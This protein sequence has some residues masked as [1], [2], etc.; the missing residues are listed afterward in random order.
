MRFPLSFPTMLSSVW[1]RLLHSP[2]LP[3]IFFPCTANPN[4]KF[5]SF[6]R[7]PISSDNPNDTSYYSSLLQSCI[8]RKSIEPGKQLHAHILLLGLGSDPI[9]GTKL[10]NLYSVCN[11]L[12]YAH[13]LFDKI[14][15][16]NIFLWNVLIRGYA[17][18]GPHEVALSLYY[19]ILDYGLK[20]DNF[21]FPFVLKACSALSAIREGR[22]IH[23][24]V[25]QT[26]WESDVFVGAALVDMY[27]KCGCVNNA[28]EVF[29]R[30][31]SRDVVLWNSMIAA[32]SQN[33]HPAEAL[34]LCREMARIGFRP[35]TATLVTVI[36]ASSDVAALPQGREIHGF[37]WRHGF[38]SQDKVKTALID[39][40]AK[41]G[42]VRVARVLFER[43]AEKRVISWNAMIS[44]YGMHGH[45]SKALSLF[46]EMKAAAQPDHITFVGVL[47]ACSHGGLIDEGWCYF[48]SMVTHYSIKP[49]VQHYTCMVDLLG[50]SGR[51]D[52]A[53]DLIMG[54][55]M[56]P[57]S[58]IWGSL[59]NSCKIHGNVE[60]GEKALQRLIDLEPEDAGN[61][62][63]LSNIYA[64]AGKWEGVAD[65]RKLMKERGLKKSIACS[66]IE[67]KN[68]VH[69]FLAGDVSHPQSD[70][71]YAELERL[72]G[73]VK[74]AGYVPD[75]GP[76][77]HD[78]DNDEKMNMVWSHSERLAIVFGLINT[79]PGTRLL[80]TKN[81]RVCDDCH[82]AIKFISKIVDREIIVR[83]VNRYH[84]FR[85]G[86]CSCGDYW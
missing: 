84:H 34:S 75:T 12:P 54:M 30:I 41:S 69:A 22:D 42:W 36:S 4:S 74:E 80:V 20:P 52:E 55:A 27:A 86:A 3:V 62:V 13:L 61:Y 78:V 5:H 65:V 2:Y 67:V 79:A 38:E 44:G 24:H 43:L 6:A 85:H 39:M 48:N 17:W 47:S 66:W 51:L 9:L 19:Q 10:V 68:K 11:S 28:R 83:D 60:L 77:F 7:K 35:T 46:E 59:L 25:V 31:S 50:H 1:R 63:I 40:Y 70:G 14:P 81:L 16:G 58:G 73:L 18:N 76:V 49:A 72:R 32:Y 56:N 71:I 21:T 45:A 29:D 15:K 37:S 8:N 53:Y 64:Q 23:E 82:T 57:D 26:G 33:S